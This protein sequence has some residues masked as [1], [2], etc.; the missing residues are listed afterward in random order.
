MLKWLILGIAYWALGVISFFVYYFVNKLTFSTFI[1]DVLCLVLGS[2][3][4][5][6]YNNRNKTNIEKFY[7]RKKF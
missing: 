5:I 7:N 3:F 6:K 1:L 2:Y 4:I